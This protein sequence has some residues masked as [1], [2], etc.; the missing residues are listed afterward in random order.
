MRSRRWLFATVVAIALLLLAGREVAGWY[1]EYRWY[2]ALGAV[3]V[4]RVK[5]WNLF[6]L[7]GV[8]FVGATLFVFVNLYAV[9]SS[10]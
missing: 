10:I 7:R 5:A 8:T 9:R 3:S 4:W 1:V 6:L 2:A